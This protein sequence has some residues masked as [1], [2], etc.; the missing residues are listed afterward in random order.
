MGGML[1]PARRNASTDHLICHDTQTVILSETIM[2]LFL[3]CFQA[4]MSLS[5][6][7]VRMRCC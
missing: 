4:A 5:L 7:E 6:S 1:P 3:R 2:A